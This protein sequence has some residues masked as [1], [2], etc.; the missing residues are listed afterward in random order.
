MSNFFFEGGRG[1][2]VQS[3]KSQV[4]RWTSVTNQ[5][6]GFASSALLA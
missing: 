6:K 1:G 2:G 5:K 4:A 3:G